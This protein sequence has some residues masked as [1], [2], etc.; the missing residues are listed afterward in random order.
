MNKMDNDMQKR[1]LEEAEAF[2]KKLGLTA[3]VEAFLAGEGIAR[4]AKNA[5]ELLKKAMEEAINNAPESV[6]KRAEEVAKQITENEEDYLL[7]VKGT[8]KL[9]LTHT[10]QTL[11]DYIAIDTMV[12]TMIIEVLKSDKEGKLHALITDMAMMIVGHIQ[13]DA[14]EVIYENYVPEGMP[15]EVADFITNVLGGGSV[16]IPLAAV[17]PGVGEDDEEDD[18]DDGSE[19][20]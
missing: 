16:M 12:R 13:S 5:Y 1:R 3:D 2:L 20:C 14:M 9:N 18:E 4:I 8:F 6:K 15:E 17:F 19:D 11:S 7:D 10:L